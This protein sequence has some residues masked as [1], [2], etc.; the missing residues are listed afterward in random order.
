METNWQ[1][2]ADKLGI[3]NTELRAEN[4][5]LKSTIATLQQRISD[6]YV[7]INRNSSNSSVP[8]SSEGLSKPTVGN[9]ADRCSKRRNRGKQPSAEGKHLEQVESL[10]EVV[11]PTSAYIVEKLSQ[12]VKL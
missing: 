2:I 5:D 12:M 7:C 6:F 4:A 9:R 8:L 1:E 11:D 10:D 3:E